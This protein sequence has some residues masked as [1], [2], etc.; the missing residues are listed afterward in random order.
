MARVYT[1][2]S[3]NRA[4]AHNEK[5]NAKGIGQIT[6]VVLEEFNELTGSTIKPEQLFEEETNMI[7][8]DW[9]MNDRIPD[10]L[11]SKGIE[12]TPQN[13]LISYNYG[14]GNLHKFLNGKVE[15]PKET[16]D[17]LY[18]YELGGDV[19]V[20]QQRLKDLGFDPG[21]IDGILGP[22]T[23]SAF[24]RFQESDIEASPIQT[25]HGLQTL[26]R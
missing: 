6:P 22:K 25:F 9:Y 16:I 24:Q 4:D 14:I 12:D 13:R 19:M 10:M 18:K 5:S 26:K 3:S 15:L 11:K 7:I 20:G 2:E 23:K 17:Y 1:I 8:S 21:P